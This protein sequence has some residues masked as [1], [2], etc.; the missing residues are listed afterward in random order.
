MKR[1]TCGFKLAKMQTSVW[2]ESGFEDPPLGPEEEERVRSI[3]SQ[4]F[5]YLDRGAQ[6]YVFQSEDQEY[7]LKIFR[8]DQPCN[9]IRSFFQKRLKTK[10]ER[11]PLEK[12][13]QHLFLSCQIAHEYAKKETALLYLHLNQTKDLLPQIELFSPLSKRHLISLD[14]YQFVLQKKAMTLRDYFLDLYSRGES[15][16]SNSS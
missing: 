7:V 6:C 15:A 8:Y 5:Y 11:A 3:L 16:G 2:I 9:P 13:I 1:Y 14:S 12:K 10:K 4:P